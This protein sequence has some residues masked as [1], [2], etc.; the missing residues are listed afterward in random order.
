MTLDTVSE[1]HFI[2]H[3]II[4]I[5]IFNLFIKVIKIPSKRNLHRISEHA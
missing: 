1:K 4:V 2:S 3:I 5:I